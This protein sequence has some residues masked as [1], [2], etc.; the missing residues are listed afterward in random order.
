MNCTPCDCHMHY[1]ILQC[2]S[3][4]ASSCVFFCR[5]LLLQASSVILIRITDS[6]MRVLRTIRFHGTSMRTLIATQQNTH[7]VCHS[8]DPREHLSGTSPCPPQSNGKFLQLQVTWSRSKRSD[9]A[10]FCLSDCCGILAV[11]DAERRPADLAGCVQ[12]WAPQPRGV[13]Q[14]SVAKQLAVQHGH[15]NQQAAR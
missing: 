9:M 6:Q 5:N 14:H 3:K 10:E 7:I 12:I 13:G 2:L 15:C 4:P 8:S 11:L 1:K